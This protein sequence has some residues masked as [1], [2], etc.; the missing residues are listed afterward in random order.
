MLYYGN[1][2]FSIHHYIDATYLKPFVL[3]LDQYGRALVGPLKVSLLDD[4]RI[5]R[6]PYVWKKGLFML[7]DW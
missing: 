5:M 6:M 7:A 4:T 2:Y 1:L 3:E